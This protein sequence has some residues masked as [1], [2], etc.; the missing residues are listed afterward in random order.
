MEDPFLGEELNI[1]MM[2]LT[3]ILAKTI[4]WEG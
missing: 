1:E 4:E 3:S 2:D